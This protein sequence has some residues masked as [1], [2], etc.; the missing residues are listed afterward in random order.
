MTPNHIN[1][2]G[3]DLIDNFQPYKQKKSQN[4]LEFSIEYVSKSIYSGHTSVDKII[5]DLWVLF[6]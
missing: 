1:F 4:Y 6:F 3:T 2:I 5:F